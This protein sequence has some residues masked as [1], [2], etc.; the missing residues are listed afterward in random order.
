MRPPWVLAAIP[1]GTV[2]ALGVLLSPL[3]GMSRAADAILPAVLPLGFYAAGLVATMLVPGQVVGQL[4]LAVGTLHLGAFALAVVAPL[5]G[6]LA[7]TWL[8]S[9][10]GLAAYALG[11]VALFD[12][13]VRY[14]DGAYAIAGLRRVVPVAALAA[15]AAGAVRALGS[16]QMPS[17]LDRTSVTPNPFRVPVLESVA[18][19]TGVFALLPLVGVL[20]MLVRYRSAPV[21]DRLQMRWPIGA[22]LAVVVGLVTTGLLQDTLGQA[23]QSAI[24]IVVASSLPA[25]FLIGLLRQAREGDRVAVLEGARRRLADAAVEERRRIERDL[26]DGAQQHLVALLSR[27]ELARQE[28][29]PGSRLDVELREVAGSIREIHRELREL[30][31]G[32]HPAI[33]S[34]RGLGEA[35]TS[36][37]GRLPLPIHLFIDPSLAGRR[38]PPAVEG[39]AYLFVLEGL[40]NVMKHSGAASGSVSLAASGEGLE[41]AV[42]DDGRGFEAGVQGAGALQ[43][44]RDRLGAVGAE[45]LVD[46]G[47]GRGTRLLGR[48]PATH[49]RAEP[50]HG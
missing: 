10:L 4:L 31:R 39:A 40:T 8:L 24:F 48:F 3:A 19:L 5:V 33:L 15:I 42:S 17:V 28:A 16:A 20:L 7:V 13:V 1:L 43:A 27:V 50:A 2:A 32:I 41:V 29:Q 9:A 11:F 44:L 26:H 14:P 18:G 34:D 6:P 35:I 30:A 22:T 45:L 47:P 36:A 12:G 21:G 25:A 23:G 37:V 38:Y 49:M 46:S